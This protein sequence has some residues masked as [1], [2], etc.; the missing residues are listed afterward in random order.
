[1]IN[2]IFISNDDIHSRL[3][4]VRHGAYRPFNWWTFP[5]I[6]LRLAEPEEIWLFA[7]VVKGLG[8][9]RGEGIGLFHSGTNTKKEATSMLHNGTNRKCEVLVHLNI[10]LWDGKTTC[11]EWSDFFENKGVGRI[12]FANCHQH[13]IDWGC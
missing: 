6:L 8:G 2:A 5:A 13:V 11:A 7:L 12:I 9:G 1:M 4:V 3:F 10:S